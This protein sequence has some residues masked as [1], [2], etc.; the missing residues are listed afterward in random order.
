MLATVVVVWAGA[1][2]AIKHLLDAGLS[3]PEVAAGRYLVAAPGFVI[4]LI[5][6][7]GLPGVSR[8][9]LG[10]IARGGSAGGRRLP[11]LAQPGRGAHRPPA[12]RR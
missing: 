5:A 4:V 12:P 10:R 2:S 6:S 1:F 8:R 7:G 3:A 11:H 9:D